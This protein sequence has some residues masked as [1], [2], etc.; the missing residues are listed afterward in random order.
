MATNL[1]KGF[2][3]KT[4]LNV[5]RSLSKNRPVH[6]VHMKCFGFDDVFSTVDRVGTYIP[7]PTVCG[8]RYY[9]GWLT[10][11]LDTKGHIKIFL[12]R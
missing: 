8:V 12:A 11:S 2:S 7:V 9:Y 6:T 5:F 10:V 4:S 3:Q 1:C